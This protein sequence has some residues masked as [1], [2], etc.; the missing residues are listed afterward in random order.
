MIQA[1]GPL[2]EQYHGRSLLPAA[3][4]LLLAAR[5]G[6][7]RSRAAQPIL[8]GALV[9]L[10]LLAA[11]VYNNFFNYHYGG[12]ANTYE[13][14]HYYMGSK[15]AHEVGYFNLY[16]ATLVADAASGRG[17]RPADG[18]LTDLA[19]HQF[20]SVDETLARA[21]DYRAL[22]SEA[23]WREFV[24]D[25]VFFRSRLGA[26]SWNR[27]LHDKGYNASPV[28]TMVGGTLSR[29]VPTGRGGGILAL[30]LLDVL[31]LLVALVAI[32]RAFGRWP[33][34]LTV[35]LLGASYLT[36][37]VHLKGAFLRTDFVVCL[38]L[39]ACL[40][41]RG[42]PASAGALVGYSTLTRLFPAVFAFGLAAKLL[43]ELRARARSTAGP[44]WRF[45]AGFALG[46]C[47]LVGAS[48][49]YHGGTTVWFDFARKMALHRGLPHIW[50]L[51]F[52][53]VADATFDV[54]SV[55]AERRSDIVTAEGRPLPAPVLSLDAAEARRP[56]KLAVALVVLA[57]GLFAVRG[58][59]DHD[60]FLFGFVA[61]F[62]CI[63]PTYYYYVVLVLPLLFFTQ[64]LDRL[65]GVCG[66]GS[67]FLLGLLGF[68]FYAR[69]DQYFPT[70]YWNAVLLLVFT[71][72][73]LAV[74][75]V[76]TRRARR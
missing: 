74:A 30:A 72:Y 9:A 65:T 49:A 50:N 63:S 22:F 20:R 37:H 67:L 59:A 17:Y 40:L 25:V 6:L 71:L 61:L 1:W 75:A 46:A 4:I 68:Q 13:F 34:G 11:L 52:S 39:A 38:V 19:T 41:K 43:W 51:G 18:T 36:A 33:A 15:Y 55:P 47:G 2:F 29:L 23:R 8:L 54:A 5:F 7:R 58:L 48:L 10:G 44:R 28:W 69:W 60:A 26:A 57:A 62:Y 21:A 12:Y 66:A 3:A 73:M 32:G 14:F 27:L 70:Y 31:L 42:W 76:E 24:G 35:V 53:T 64:R 16:N 45:F 56:L